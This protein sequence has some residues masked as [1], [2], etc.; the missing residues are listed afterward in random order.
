MGFADFPTTNG[1]VVDR[2]WPT[3]PSD[4]K[5]GEVVD[6]AVDQ[7]GDVLLFNRGENPVIVV[8]QAGQFQRTW[9][10]GIFTRP[11]AIDVAPD[12]RI[13][14]TDDTDHSVRIFSAEGDLL[15]TLGKPGTGS[16]FLSGN[17]FYKCTDATIG[18]DGSIY[19]CDGYGNA[20]VHKFDCDGNFLKSWG[21][22]GTEPGQF[23]IPH[24]IGCDGDGLLYVADRENHRVQV[25]DSDGAFVMQWP[26]YRA[27]GLYVSRSHDL[28][29]VTEDCPSREAPS[30]WSNVGARV[31][32]TDRRGR[33]LE[34]FGANRPGHEGSAFIAPHGVSLGKSGDIYVADLAPSTW[35]RFFT[36]PVPEGLSSVMRIGH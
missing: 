28:C 36:A 23:I 34:R 25:F 18:N 16:G 32:V 20:A 30:G 8:D 15:Q 7:N 22:P 31:L 14:C 21:S 11:H 17:P 35:S 33:I 5:M 26:V 24:N 4:L 19:V 27:Q 12:G 29:I 1:H 3:L 13:L 6:T 9:G 2:C 10:Q